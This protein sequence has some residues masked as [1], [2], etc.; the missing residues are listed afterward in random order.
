[1]RDAGTMIIAPK[2]VRVVDNALQTLMGL[3]NSGGSVVVTTDSMSSIV[4]TARTYNQTGNGTYGQFIPAV[5]PADSAELGG[6]ALQI[7]QIEES[8]RFRTNLGIF[9]VSG[10]PAT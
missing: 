7:L 4:A 6:R 5:T 2:E 1:G 3:Q 8:D 9:E 10:K